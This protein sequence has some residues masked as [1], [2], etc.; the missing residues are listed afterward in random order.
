MLDSLYTTLFRP[1]EAPVAPPLRVAWGI[2][3]L[4]S[5][6]EAMRFAGVLS[7]GPGG[8]VFM[9]LLVFVLNVAG[10][11]WLAAASNLLAQVLGGKGSAEPTLTAIAQAFWPL[12]LLA[13]LAA[14]EPWLG[15]LAPLLTFGVF[16]WAYYGVV[17]AISRAH[18][19]SMGRSVLVLLGSG[20]AVGLGLIALVLTPV[21]GVLSAL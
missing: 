12:I 9:L 1:S 8:L 16:V 3:F 13:P 2:W 7:L 21:L 6:L 17:R 5:L 14:A 19:L 20:A 15:L 10:W 11:F 18:A 4:L